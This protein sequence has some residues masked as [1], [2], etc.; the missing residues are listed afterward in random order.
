MTNSWILFVDDERH[1]YD[2]GWSDHMSP[3][4]ARTSA[5]AI[6]LV[7]QKGLPTA[8]SFDHDLGGEDTAFKFMW[9]LI[10]GHLDSTWDL[11]GIQYI[12]IHTAN[13]VGREKLIALWQ[14][15]CSSQQIDCKIVQAWP[16][17]VG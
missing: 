5:E 7:E 14:S 17:S 10:D 4:V 11:R 15:F 16:R 3:T 12:Q 2:V 9:A 1:P 8:I 6:S 13:V